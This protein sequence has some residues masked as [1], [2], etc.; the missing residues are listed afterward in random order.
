MEPHNEAVCCLGDLSKILFNPQFHIK[1]FHST[2]KGNLNLLNKRN[3]G[4]KRFEKRDNVK[5]YNN[6]YYII[7]I[8][9]YNLEAYCNTYCFNRKSRLRRFGFDISLRINLVLTRSLK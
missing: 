6:L 1:T 2:D 8:C 7:I 5:D 3:M 4:S 9:Y